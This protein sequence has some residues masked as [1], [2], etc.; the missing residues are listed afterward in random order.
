MQLLKLTLSLLITISS[1]FSVNWI[2]RL[3]G[4]KWPD[5]KAVGD[6]QVAHV[7]TWPTL[8]VNTICIGQPDQFKSDWYGPGLSGESN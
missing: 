1:K 6:S 5:Y 7:S 2:L 8:Q 3:I 4:P